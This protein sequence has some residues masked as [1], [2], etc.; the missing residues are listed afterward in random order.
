MLLMKYCSFYLITY[1]SNFIVMLIFSFSSY[2]SSAL[3]LKI[4]NCQRYCTKCM[5]LLTYP[6]FGLCHRL[7][8]LKRDP[9]ICI[10]SLNLFIALAKCWLFVSRARYVFLDFS[11]PVL[12]LPAL[13]SELAS[14]P[15]NICH[16]NHKHL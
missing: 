6:A 14:L 16:R 12:W 11:F 15:E 10:L 4:L 13:F 7:S 2:K 1:T 3:S 9:S 8:G 5:I